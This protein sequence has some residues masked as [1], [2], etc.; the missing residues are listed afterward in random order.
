[1]WCCASKWKG[2]SSRTYWKSVRALTGVRHKRFDRLNASPDQ[3]ISR[4]VGRDPQRRN[5]DGGKPAANRAGSLPLALLLLFP[6]SLLS[7]PTLR[8][9]FDSVHKY[10]VGVAV[11][12]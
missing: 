11:S 2:S 6:L 10:A 9:L 7:P 12:Q 3:E 1:M 5:K 8:D 4:R